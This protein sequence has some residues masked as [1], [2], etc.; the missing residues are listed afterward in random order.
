MKNR[1]E[2]LN[3][4]D[5]VHLLAVGFGSG[6]IYPAPGTWGSL[7]GLLLGVI[8]LQYLSLP[9]FTLFTLLAFIAGCYFCGK[10]AEDMGV[11]DH[12]SIVW[13]EFVGIFLVL[14]A[15]PRLSWG[16]CLL[17]FLAFR[18]FDII[19]PYP[20]GYFD[21]KLQTGFGIMLDDV[22]AAFYAILVIFLLRILF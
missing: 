2:G 10:T 12:S 11:H 9:L 21:Q 22:L 20:I 3:L 13:D 6:L 16:W 8:L 7:A 5:P 18:L 15:L 4:F 1:F 17:A 14:L 19:K